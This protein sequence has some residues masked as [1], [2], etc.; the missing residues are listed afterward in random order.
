MDKPVQNSQR[1]KKKAL[2]LNFLD[3]GITHAEFLKEDA[4]RLRNWLDSGFH[5]EME[6]MG[7]HFD[8]RTDPRKLVERARSLIVVLE[9]YHADEKQSDPRAPKISKYVYGKD[10]HKIIRKKLNS[11]LRWIQDEISR[12]SAR[13]FVDSA[14]VMEK[15]VAA[16]A[17]LGWIGKHS[18]L[19]NRRYGSW[20]FIGVIISDLELE[21]D[22]P[23]EEHCGDCTKCIDAC[24]TS[25]ILPGRMI[26][27]TRCIS[28]LTVDYKG[29]EIPAEFRDR[30]QN[31]AF[32]CDICQ[33]VC[34]WNKNAHP[35]K[36]AW[37]KPRPGL[38]DMSR[39]EW[40]NLDEKKFNEHFEGSAVKRAG[41]AGLRRNLDF[42]Q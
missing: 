5:G 22:R 41:F 11:L 33:D 15:A 1:I 24:P 26:D 21:T 35:H 12:V 13:V 34:P 38:L 4:E 29:D 25:A 14:P 31:R 16:R 40:M 39:K 9:N 10:Y 37:F 6:Y 36:E 17:G 23:V 7:N 27:A 42:L 30:M 20:F 28:Y 32:G 18:L 2:E 8:K 3:C 19:L